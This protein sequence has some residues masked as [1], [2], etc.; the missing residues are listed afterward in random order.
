[1][2]SSSVEQLIHRP[3]YMQNIYTDCEM[4]NH[5]SNNGKN[6]GTQYAWKF[7]DEGLNMKLDMREEN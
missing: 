7:H 6:L 3:I 2:V 4:T 5:N 1:M